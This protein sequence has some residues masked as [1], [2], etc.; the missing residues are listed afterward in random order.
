MK[1]ISTKKLIELLILGFLSVSILFTIVYT[2]LTEYTVGNKFYIGA[3]SVALVVALRFFNERISNYLLGLIL[4]VGTFNLISISFIDISFGFYINTIGIKVNFF[5]LFVFLFYL[6]VNGKELS[7][8]FGDKELT[9]E[10]KKADAEKL[11]EMYITQHSNKSNDE[12]QIIVDNPDEYVNSAVI[13][14][15]R[16]LDMKNVP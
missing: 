5:L 12:L 10:E 13:A 6:T 4:I 2:S 15:K 8:L 1:K 9:E 11:I 16:I 7:T 14:A 3:V